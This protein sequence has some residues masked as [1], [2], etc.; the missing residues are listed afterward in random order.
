MHTSGLKL[1]I[2]NMSIRLRDRTFCPVC[3]KLVRLVSFADAAAF[4]KV[5]EPEIERLGVEGELH[6]LHNRR[7]RLMIC[8]DSLFHAFDKRQTRLLP[9]LGE[10]TN[11]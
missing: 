8:S 7:A 2:D 9:N 6:R 11:I 10:A 5:S 3:Q 4:F 1:N